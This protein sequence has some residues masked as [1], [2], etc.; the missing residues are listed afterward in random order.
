MKLNTIKAKLL[1]LVLISVFL[2][3]ASLGFYNA[4]NAYK[5]QNDL[6]KQKELNLAKQ[7]SKFIDSYLQAKINI[8]KAVEQELPNINLHT[9]NKEIIKTLSL[10]KK[11]GNFVDLYVGFE[12]NGDFLLSTGHFLNIK[13]DN[14]DARSRPWYKRA[15]EI[16]KAG[17][18]KPYV[19]IT[20]KKLVVTVFTPFIRNNKILGV[21]GSDIFLDTVVDSILNVEI[22]HEGFAYLIGNDGTTLIHRDKKL[23]NSKHK[24]FKQ[25]RSNKDN[26]F[27]IA[28]KNG[29]KKLISYSKIPV[30]SW[31]LTVELDKDTVFEKINN[32]VIQ[33]IALYSVLLVIILLIL[34][35]YLVK[36]LSPLKQLEN[37]LNLFFDYLKG[38]QKQVQKL[39]I[40]TNDELGNM[41]TLIDK[42]METVAIN[43]DKDRELIE[44]VKKVVNRVKEGKFDYHVQSTTGNESLNELKDILNDMIETTSNNVDIDINTILTS[45]NNYSNLNFVDDI[46]KPTGNVSKGLNN[47]CDIINHMLQ[48]NK[49]HGVTIDENAKVLLTNVDILNRSSNETAAS[50]EETAAALEEITSTIVSNTENIGQMASYSHELT[51]SI[52]AGQNLANTT[53]D[54]MNEIDSQTE[55]IAEAITVIDQIAFQTNILSLNAAVE[56]A[57]AGEAGKGFAVVA[58]EVRNLASR[59]ADAAK[60]IKALVE[61]ATTK[62]SAGKQIADKMITGYEELNS[63]IIK[64]TETINDISSASKEQQVGIEQINDAV[65]RLDQQTQQNASVATHTHDIAINTSKIAKTIIDSVNRK[66]FREN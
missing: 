24:L 56:A 28:S 31:Y 41:A 65:T 25:V 6:I 50:L 66:K 59:S 22:E 39:G 20:T 64:T 47:L 45:I 21:V 62:T 7:T 46:D 54:A 36:I 8:V 2:S 5:L 55:A 34:Y 14:F 49:N 37:G 30:T 33:E 3:F 53:V 40:N 11:A 16:K 17:V 44:D 35:F 27:G 26:N 1:L 38:E 12:K 58:Q 32:K 23:L 51:C 60:E 18:T 57:T 9:K 29:I 43:L 61:N 48:E 19:D 10:G 52:K 4:Q 63:N 13:K 42:E 15:L